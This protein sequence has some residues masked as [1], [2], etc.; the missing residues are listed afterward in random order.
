MRQQEEQLAGGSWQRQPLFKDAVYRGVAWQVG[1]DGSVIGASTFDAYPEG[2]AGPDHFFTIIEDPV[3]GF[4]TV[5]IYRLRE[6]EPRVGE[7]M[8]EY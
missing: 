3:S 8:T 4:R 1:Q 7:T 5:R 2:L 6:C